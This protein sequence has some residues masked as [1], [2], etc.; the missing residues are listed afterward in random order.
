[1]MASGSQDICSTVSVQHDENF[2]TNSWASIKHY[3]ISENKLICVDVI[4]YPD[5]CVEY[6][7]IDK[8]YDSQYMSLCD[9]T[10]DE[11]NMPPFVEDGKCVSVRIKLSENQMKYLVGEPGSWNTDIAQMRLR[12]IEHGVI[13]AIDSTEQD[14][15]F[16]YL[17]WSTYIKLQ[18]FKK[19][20]DVELSY[21][22]QYVHISSNTSNCMINN[23]FIIKHLM[24][25]IAS[26]IY[27]YSFVCLLYPKLEG[28]NNS[29][30]KLA[31]V[32]R[33][34]FKQIETI[35]S[36][37][38]HCVD[39]RVIKDILNQCSSDIARH[40]SRDYICS[41]AAFFTN[42]LTYTDCGYH[43]IEI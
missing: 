1:M 28:E 15:Q 4:V 14:L 34:S 22:L 27:G 6:A 12:N 13:F 42:H 43:A 9:W 18:K 33:I 24:V 30:R 17:S 2:H 21:M 29:Q 5:R 23:R 11:Y 7:L 36:H 10:R 8:E 35:L 38:N 39:S 3:T 19:E 40:V 31:A 37:S 26:K 25:A 32:K 41:G 16:M 20:N